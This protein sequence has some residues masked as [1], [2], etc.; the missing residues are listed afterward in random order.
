[1][2]L[3][4]SARG[5]SARETADPTP[6]ER[7]IFAFTLWASFSIAAS[8]CSSSGVSVSELFAAISASNSLSQ[9]EEFVGVRNDGFMTVV[10]EPAHLLFDVK[11][12]GITRFWKR[13]LL[14]GRRRI[15]SRALD[16]GG[17]RG[18]NAENRQQRNEPEC[19]A[20]R[21]R[22]RSVATHRFCLLVSAHGQLHLVLQIARQYFYDFGFANR[23]AW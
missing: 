8:L 22:R 7:T 6:N 12:T 3:P 13:A 14:M 20:Y 1:M 5:K 17:N 18:R 19:L 21:S 11:R 2:D 9:L 4:E 10:V 23:S 15:E 16:C